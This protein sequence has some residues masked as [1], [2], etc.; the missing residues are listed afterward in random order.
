MA[1][2]KVEKAL[3]HAQSDVEQ[4]ITFLAAEESKKEE[5]HEKLRAGQVEPCFLDTFV[6]FL[7]T[8]FC[9]ID[10]PVC[11]L[12]TLAS[13]LDTPLLLGFGGGGLGCPAP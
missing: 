1:A 11:V 3:R 2:G 6:C 8:P 13:F 4:K 10:T 12:D 9:L 7:E 5:L